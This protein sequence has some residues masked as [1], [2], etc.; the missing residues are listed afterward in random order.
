MISIVKHKKQVMDKFFHTVR[1]MNMRTF[2]IHSIE[3]NIKAPYLFDPVLNEYGG[4]NI[5]KYHRLL[6][7]IGLR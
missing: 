3:I 1:I 2:Y 6:L 7:M 5:T 4:H